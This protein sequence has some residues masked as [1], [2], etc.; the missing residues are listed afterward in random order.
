MKLKYRVSKYWT[1]ASALTI[2]TGFFI[3]MEFSYASPPTRYASA[4]VFVSTEK[5]AYLF[6]GRYEGIFGT[7]YR[8]DL[9]TFDYA[10]K[11][12]SRMRAHPRPPARGNFAMVYDSD[13]H[14]LILFG[15]IA[16]ERLGDT[17]IYDIAQNMWLE[18]SP[19]VSPP[20]RSDT[21]MVYDEANHAAILFSGYGLEDSRYSY[22]D[23]WV[24]DP[25]TSTWTEMLPA[26]SPPMMYGQTMVYD[27]NNHQ[28]LLWGGHA[29]DYQ[30][31]SL[32]SHW[33]EDNL[34]HYDY[35][36]NT[37]KKLAYPV[38]PPA[39]YW[40]QA[41][42]NTEND[43]ILVFGGNGAH[44]FLDDTW[45]MQIG[46]KTWTRIHTEAPPSARIN[47]AM[48]YDATHHVVILFGGLEQDHT[49]LQ[50]T[51]IFE[52]RNARGQWTQIEP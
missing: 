33:Y 22:D 38:K 25:G 1:I 3:W 40:H 27:S 23:T 32:I 44:S 34:W 36:N 2:V 21:G 16:K 6:G 41:A 20:P 10:A 31:G 4:L 26:S 24:Y 18:V 39:R 47:A 5:K 48:T 19:E 50:D 45:L 42:F 43:Q 14:Q 8:N 49:D 11:S 28:V 46:E 15:G 9:W 51:W 29:S 37:W 35:S 7:A 12:W 52:M 30:G 17:W 13:R